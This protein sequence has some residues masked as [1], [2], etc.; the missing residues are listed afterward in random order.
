LDKTNLSQEEL[1]VKL[2]RAV[3]EIELLENTVVD[4]DKEAKK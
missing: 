1:A 2:E 3:R 4:M